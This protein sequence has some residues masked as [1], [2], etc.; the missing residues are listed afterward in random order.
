VSKAHE[1]TIGDE[2]KEPSYPISSVDSA[3]RLLLMLRDADR[4]RV[5]EAARALGVGRSTAHRLLAMLQFHGFVRQDPESRAYLA[6]PTLVE[7]GLA[8]VRDIDIREATLPY[9]EQVRDQIGETAHLVVLRGREAFFL[10]SVESDRTVRAGQRIGALLPAHCTAA[11][12]VLLA[13][14]SNEELRLR[15]PRVKLVGLTEQSV[16]HRDDLEAA[17][18][19]IRSLGYATNF[20]E[21]E[22]DLAAVAAPIFAANGKPLAALSISAP[23]TRLS[24]SSAEEAAAALMVIAGAAS[25]EIGGF[26]T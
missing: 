21:S 24:P 11:G 4:L 22:T 1:E 19:T 3:L 16:V 2:T 10:N 25:R 14:L 8:A 9:L 7:I 5:A 6:G 26:E 20:G 18:A 13:N 23:M 12:K 15:Y 17:L